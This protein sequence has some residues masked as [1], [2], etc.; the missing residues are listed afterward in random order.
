MKPV[1][2][3]TWGGALALSL[4]CASAFAYAHPVRSNVFSSSAET[5]IA[6]VQAEKKKASSCAIRC[7]DYCAD[8]QQSFKDICLSQ[9]AAQCK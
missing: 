1:C 4:L 6:R 2:R 9:C 5:L 7:R 3:M 8:K